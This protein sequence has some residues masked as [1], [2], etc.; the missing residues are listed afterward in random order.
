MRV[1]AGH[2]IH[3]MMEIG[4]LILSFQAKHQKGRYVPSERIKTTISLRGNE[5]VMLDHLPDNG[6]HHKQNRK[7]QKSDQEDFGCAMTLPHNH[8]NK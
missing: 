5:I 7:Y 2:L 1:I 3:V 8:A 6:Q 4:Y